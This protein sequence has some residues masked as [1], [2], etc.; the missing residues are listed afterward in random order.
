MDILN[1]L[2]IAPKVSK[3]CGHRPTAKNNIYTIILVHMNI[4][5]HMQTCSYTYLHG[6][7]QEI[8]Q[9]RQEMQQR[10]D[11][12]AQE[13]LREKIE[14]ENVKTELAS[15]QQLYEQQ[16]QRVQVLEEQYVAAQNKA[17]GHG[18]KHGKADDI[19]SGER[20]RPQRHQHASS[21]TQLLASK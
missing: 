14:T 8:E 16:K 17:A 10:L 19:A 9:E 11:Q 7:N 20:T 5:I 18:S 12:W 2:I 3:G 21:A 15:V 4:H 13:R 6:Q 1:S